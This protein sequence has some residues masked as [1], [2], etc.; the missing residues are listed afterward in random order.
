MREPS[1][2]AGEGRRR[3]SV[4]RGTPA[5]PIV[6]PGPPTATRDDTAVP[7]RIAPLDGEGWRHRFG[8][9]GSKP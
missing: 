7:L 9:K 1:P 8:G 6:I 3:W 2:S 4:L 5:Q